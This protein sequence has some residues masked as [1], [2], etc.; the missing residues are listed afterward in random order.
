MF[1]LFSSTSHSSTSDATSISYQ[2]EAGFKIT[3]AA[4]SA[5]LNRNDFQKKNRSDYY[6]DIYDGKNYFFVDT[7]IISFRQL[8]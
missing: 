4:A 7:G 5:V 3:Q 8:Q 1:A 2:T 6:V